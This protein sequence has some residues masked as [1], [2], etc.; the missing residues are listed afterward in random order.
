MLRYAATLIFI[1]LLFPGE[2]GPQ[3]RAL[4]IT[5]LRIYSE[6]ELVDI[7]GLHRFETNEITAKEAIDSI[8]AF[9]SDRG[10]TL[11]KV[12]VI[13]NS[14]TML[15]LYIDEG[16][17]GK[18]IFLN[19]DDF[20]T[21]YLQITFRLKN[22]IFNI[23]T[24]NENIEKLKGGRRWKNITYQLKPVKEFSGSIF[25]LDRELDLP[26][27]G[28]RQLPFFD[29]FSPRYDL[30]IIFSRSIIPIDIDEY[31]TADKNGGAPK[32][33][34][35]KKKKLPTLNKFDYGL[36]VHLHKGFIPFFKYYHL[37]LITP[38]DFFISDTSAGIMY[39]IDRKFKRP[40]RETYFNFNSS[41]FFTPTFKDIFTPLLRLNLYQSKAGRPDLGL[42]AYNYLILNTML[43]PG[44]TFLNK[45]N[46]Y[47][48]FGVETAFFFNSTINKYK[49]LN[50]NPVSLITGPNTMLEL[51]N[52][53]NM[54]SL[55]KGIERRT[56]VYSY[57]EAGFI[58]DFTKRSKKVYELR[59]NRLK[60]EIAIIY[61]FYFL[62]RTFN[63]LR[64][65]AYFEHEFKDKNIYSGMLSYQI[66]F[67][68]T[69]FYHESSVS[70]PA[71]KGLQGH[72]YYSKNILSQSNEYRISMY[73]DFLYI[74][75]FF[76]MTLFEGTGRDVRG[77]QFGFV[78][79]P[80]GRVLLFDHFELFI[81]YGWDFL[82][83]TKNSKG[84]LYF[85]IQNKW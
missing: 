38:G 26:L 83:S 21:I 42:L 19:M 5:G 13:E 12:Y 84:Y 76:D 29:R 2:P 63:K 57:I 30:V 43:A 56:D 79:G 70:N 48:G 14:E 40:P 8:I 62:K 52:I 77:A 64:L 66:T 73:R 71:F 60:K 16:S 28:K 32:I 85:N 54:I 67:I 31:S 4:E 82:V 47:T 15:K 61:N 59:K 81:Y 72:A 10:Y 58:Y 22:K 51:E 46:L 20:T 9:Y 6:E 11:I 35:R 23:N 69:P 27:I 37:G 3:E 25:Q 33:D 80:T 17:L 1:A 24:V 18:I 74:G 44:I 36:K 39:G 75:A 50:L 55:Y 34:N 68:N 65:V 78:G 45:F 49:L 7:L 41:Y 53:E